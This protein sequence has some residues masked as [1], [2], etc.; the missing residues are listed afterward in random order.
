MNRALAFILLSTLCL[1]LC[2]AATVT[3]LGQEERQL[4]CLTIAID[5]R[6]FANVEYSLSGA[7][8]NV[9]FG[10][11]ASRDCFSECRA[12]L[13]V[14]LGESPRANLF[15]R[16][17][18]SLS[19]SEADSKASTVQAIFSARFHGISFQKVSESHERGGHI[20]VFNGSGNFSVAPKVFANATPS[21]GLKKLINENWIYSCNK[22]SIS[23]SVSDEIA[24]RVCTI[25]VNARVDTGLSGSGIHVFDLNAFFMRSGFIPLVNSS[26]VITL[27]IGSTDI[28]IDCGHASYSVSDNTI[29]ISSTTPMAISNVIVTFTYNFKPKDFTPPTVEILSPENGSTVQGTIKVVVNVSDDYGIDRVELYLN[30]TMVGVL[31]SPPWE[32]NLD[33]SKLDDGTYILKVTAYDEV[34][35]SNS[36]TIVIK[37]SNKSQQAVPSPLSFNLSTLLIICVAV[38]VAIALI[39]FIIKKVRRR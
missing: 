8:P 22:I 1:A 20:Y 30:D 29:V 10:I 5:E 15:I 2:I 24:R 9:S 36:E 26:I 33:T 3:V 19:K 17:P 23:F 38:A 4:E 27:P 25:A 14:T 12:T 35:N 37:V 32:F 28:S 7:Y 11:D 21:N 6:G 16:Y 18:S 39:M 13:I 34:G 31:S